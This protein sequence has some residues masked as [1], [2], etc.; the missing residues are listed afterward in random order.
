MKSGLPSQCSDCQ[1]PR[2][3][4]KNSDMEAD[5]VAVSTKEMNISAAAKNFSVPRKTLDDRVKGHVVH[6]RRPGVSTVLT[7]DEETSLAS[8]LIYM[9]ERGFP[10][11]RNGSSLCLGIAKRSGKKKG[12]MLIMVL[13]I[14]GGPY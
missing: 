12:L 9:A 6:G 7:P 13:V 3:Q 4:W 8:Y 14:I 2:L 10:L 1:T 5:M 11:T